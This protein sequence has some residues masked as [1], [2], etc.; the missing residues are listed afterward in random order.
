M[1]TPAML[2]VSHRGRVVLPS[3]T[4]SVG[5]KGVIMA[6][7]ARLAKTGY[8]LQKYVKKNVGQYG[9]YFNYVNNITKSL[10][11]GQIY[12]TITV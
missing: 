4:G 12:I 3:Q 6:L 11:L 8:V 10:V 1:P 2:E 5:Y 7:I 9:Y